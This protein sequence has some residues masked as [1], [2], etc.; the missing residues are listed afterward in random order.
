[1][2]DMQTKAKK[3][4]ILMLM[5][6]FPSSQSQITAAVVDAYL[7]A[8]ENCSPDAVKRSCA[9]FLAGKVADHNNSFLPTAAEL[10]ANARQWDNAIAQVTAD[11][12]LAL[13]QKMTVYKIGETPPPPLEALGP[14]KIEIN[15]VPTDVSHLTLADKEVVL[16]T[17]KMPDADPAQSIG[18]TPKF[19]RP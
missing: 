12:A 19:R 2:T 6:G 11:R 18:F 16:K 7:A 5:H 1:M 3:A 13:A 15:G 4:E 8:V 10:S 17:G 9:Q 14:T